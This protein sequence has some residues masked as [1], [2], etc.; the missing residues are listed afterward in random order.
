MVKVKVEIEV[1]NSW[2]IQGQGVIVELKN[3]E[4]GLEKG[5]RLISIHSGI[6]WKVKGRLIFDHTAD[7]QKRFHNETEIQV[8][9][10]FNPEENKDTSRKSLLDNESQGIYQYLIEFDGHNE[11]PKQFEKLKIYK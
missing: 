10:S 5:T 7:S 6:E 9:V 2:T 3:L 11:K 8:H 4:T 1:I